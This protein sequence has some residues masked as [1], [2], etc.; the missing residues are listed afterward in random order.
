MSC[1]IYIYIYTK[2]FV[3]NLYTFEH[4][5][6][7]PQIMNRSKNIS[8]EVFVLVVFYLRENGHSTMWMG[9]F[10][11]YGPGKTHFFFAGMKHRVPPNPLIYHRFPNF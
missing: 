5:N 1:N 3:S 10:F 11:F 9:Q 7:G 2:L 8:A 4:P 6:V